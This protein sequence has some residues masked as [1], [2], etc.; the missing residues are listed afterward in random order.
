VNK[1]WGA[2]RRRTAEWKA[3]QYRPIT[4]ELLAEK[5]A[6]VR[7]RTFTPQAAI[8]LAQMKAR[9]GSTAKDTA[10]WTAVAEYLMEQGRELK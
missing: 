10:L 3:D 9:T 6:W 4:P 8:G 1:Q 7:E 2:R 5:A